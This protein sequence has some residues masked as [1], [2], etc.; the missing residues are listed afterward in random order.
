MYYNK[1][2]FGL[3]PDPVESG[4]MHS[5]G[6]ERCDFGRFRG[7]FGRT[8]GC[9]VLY[10]KPCRSLAGLVCPEPA[11]LARFKEPCLLVLPPVV[12]ALVIAPLCMSLIT[13]IYLT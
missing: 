8:S 5:S 10:S 7:G 6:A 1:K 12:V 3:K 11:G 4:E 13:L 2:W 9:A